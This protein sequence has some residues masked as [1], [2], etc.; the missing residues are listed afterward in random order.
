MWFSFLRKF[1][2]FALDNYKAVV[3]KTKN[4]KLSLYLISESYEFLGVSFP[5]I[6]LKKIQL[7]MGKC[8]LNWVR[9]N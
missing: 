4:V 3:L 8:G 1:K 2:F 9:E 6:N 7:K 5:F